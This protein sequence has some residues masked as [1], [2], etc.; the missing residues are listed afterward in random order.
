MLESQPQTSGLLAPAATNTESQVTDRRGWM[1]DTSRGTGRAVINVILWGAARG[2][3]F[4]CAGVEED[5]L[6]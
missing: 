5:T 3:A 2:R 6:Q 1:A 4:E